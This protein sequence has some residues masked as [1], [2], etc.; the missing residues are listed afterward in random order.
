[1]GRPAAVLR[2]EAEA[3]GFWDAY[4]GD[5]ASVPWQV[6]NVPDNVYLWAYKTYLD[7]RWPSAFRLH[8]WLYTPYGAL[9]NV[10]RLEADEALFEEIARDSLQDATI[11]FAAVRLGGG[12]YFGTSLTGFPVR[13]MAEAPRKARRLSEGLKM[14]LKAV[15][16]F[17]LSTTQGNS[18]PSIGYAGRGHIGGW[19]ESVQISGEDV[20]DFLLR[21]RGG[22]A[23]SAGLLPARAALL[24]TNATIIGFRVYRSGG[25]A[26][27]AFAAAYPGSSGLQ[28][29]VPQMAILCKGGSTSFGV[30][31]RWTVRGIPDSQIDKGE[32]APSPGYAAAVQNYFRALAN[33]QFLAND[34]TAASGSIFSVSD[35]GLVTL[36]ANSPFAVNAFVTMNKLVTNT[37]LTRLKTYIS[38][39][40]PLEM[41]FTVAGWPAGTT[42]TSGTVSVKTQGAF[43]LDFANSSVVRA[44]VRKVGRNFEPYRGR[45]SKR[46][47]I[48]Q[49]A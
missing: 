14:A 32:F 1:M 3:T 36:K 5:G 38:G 11:V 18:D 6:M 49:V 31:R 24:P 35:A 40:G 37:G 45:R 16:L 27:Q 13:N 19:S 26:A 30:T 39:I 29:D 20:A 43:N 21:L 15:I 17:Q 23:Y 10:T 47:K 41:Q 7:F 34:P 44:I 4:V 48:V 2:A 33:F 22:G 9:I 8:D 42:A 46:R 12:P 28:C 25:G